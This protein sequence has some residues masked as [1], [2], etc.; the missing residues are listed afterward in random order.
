MDYLNYSSLLVEKNDDGIAIL[1]FNQPEQLN[2]FDP[3]LHRQVED[4]FVD[5]ADDPDVKVIIVTGEGKAFS[6][7]GNVKEMV[8]RHGT[9]AGWKRMSTGMHAVKRLLENI[10]SCYKPT[11]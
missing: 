8:K 7:G 2:A 6:A 5:L 3:T 11:I 9:E 10:L 1:K 4:V